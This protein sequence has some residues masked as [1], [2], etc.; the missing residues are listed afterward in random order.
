MPPTT[1]AIDRLM[2]QLRLK[3]PLIAVYDAAPGEAFEPLIEAT[4]H[5]CCFAYYRKWL[6][7]EALH[8]TRDCFGCGGAGYW[9]CGQV[10]RPREAFV[11]FL[12]DD[13]GLKAS[14]ELMNEWLDH[15]KPYHQK[16]D[17]LLVGPL[18]ETEYEYLKTITFLVDP[19]QLSLLMLGARYN[20]CPSDPPPVFAPFGSGCMQLVTVFDDLDAPQASVG[21]TDIAMRQF[22]PRDILAFTVTKS[23][24]MQ[25]CA[26]DKD[27][28]LY[29][30]FWKGLHQARAQSR[31]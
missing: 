7:G 23:M 11:K 6:A 26:L 31:A 22:F 4:G 20:S 2:T 16:H 25:L 27:S 29:K 12:V 5:T 3:T 17:H 18:R 30:P 24:F 1:D 15:E 19:D 8:L 28:F 21:A 9:L 14:H 10:G 13:E